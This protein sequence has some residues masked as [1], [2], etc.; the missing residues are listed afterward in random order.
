MTAIELLNH[1]SF[2]GMDWLIIGLGV[3]LAYVVF[4]IAGFGTAL[5]AAPILLLLMPLSKI[6]PLLVLLDFVAAF[7]GLL[8]TRRE[9]SKAE[10]LRLL[11]C[12][13]IGC[14]LGVVFLLNLHSDLLLLLMGLFISAYAI[15]SLLVKARPTQLAAGWSVPMGTVGGLFGAMFGSGGFLYAI[16]LNSRLPK[17]SARA[18]Q[19]ALISAS[20][21]VRL[22]L[23]LLAGVYADWPLLLL[24]LCLLPAMGLGLWFGRRLTLRL[25]REAFVKVVT[26]LVL[27]SGLALIG[28]YLSS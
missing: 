13:A 21:L 1:W 9:V 28:R 5:I 3:V 6:I 16:Y 2:A 25:S 11:P 19:S 7:G 14:T 8:H 26:W 4:G 20:T 17:E 12:M 15:Y 23:F 22:S 27:A 24:A 18:T 10:L